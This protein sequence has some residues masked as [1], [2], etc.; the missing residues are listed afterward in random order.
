MIVGLILLGMTLGAVLGVAAL[1]SGTPL[2]IA[3]TIYVVAGSFWTLGAI[4]V[5]SLRITWTDSHHAE[6]VTA[7]RMNSAQS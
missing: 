5:L 2:A 4:V 3:I 7:Q 1:I 6:Q